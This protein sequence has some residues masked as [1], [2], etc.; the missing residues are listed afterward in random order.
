MH[1]S[2]WEQLQ[3]E[4][5]GREVVV[6]ADDARFGRFAGKKGRVVAVNRN[7]RVLVRFEGTADEGWHDFDLDYVKVYE[8]PRPPVDAGPVGAEK[9][10]AGSL[11][12][13]TL[14]LARRERDA[15]K[16]KGSS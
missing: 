3:S 6:D 12:P 13:S 10:E 5:V 15:A 11:R 9:D 2:R 7:G 8:P 16:E 1:E 4:Y 14:E